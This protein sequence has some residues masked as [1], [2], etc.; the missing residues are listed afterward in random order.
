MK[1]KL[2][3]ILGPNA[4]GK[5]SLGIH[6]AKK[7]NGEIIS[8]DSTQV[9]KGLDLGTGKVTEEEMDG[10]KHHLIDI[11]NPGE[12]FSVFDFQKKAYEI[13]DDI[14][15]RGKTP[16]IVGGTGLYIRSITKGYNL[17]ETAIDMDYRKTLEEKSLEHLVTELENS[18]I[19]ISKIDI[20]NKRRVIRA[21][22]KLKIG[23]YEAKDPSIKYDCLELGLAWDK[24]KQQELIN[25]RVDERIKQG[26]IEEI[27]TLRK[28]GVSD[29][30]LETIGLDYR[31]T[32]WY[33]TNKF[34]SIEEYTEELKRADRKYAKR[35]MTWFKKDENVIWLDT[36]K[37]YY[38]EAASHIEKSKP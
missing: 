35:Q 32:L 23:E 10:I 19:D 29:E 9:Y 1:P 8:A 2:I 5:S 22:E 37:D 36:K 6:L 16:F 25:D 17:T 28:N 30:F 33:L 14:I 12:N 7:Y 3:V 4:S 18:H 20:K 24:E 31:Y 11:L 15:A 34:K 27:E 21:L 38:E 26:M 13:I